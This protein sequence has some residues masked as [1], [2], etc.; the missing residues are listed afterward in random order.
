MKRRLVILM[1]LAA[2]GGPAAAA[3]KKPEPKLSFIFVERFRVEA[4]DNA[5]SLDRAA[6]DSTA[7]TRNR[8]TLGLRWLASPGLE[9]LGK[10]TNEF[11]SYLAPKNRPFTWNEAFVDNLY[12]RGTIPGQVPLTI[13]A[14]RQ[15]I[16]LGEGFVIADSTPLDGSRSYYFNALRV[17]AGLGPKRTL[18]LFVHAQRTTDRYLPVIHSQSQALVEQPEKALA[19]YYSGGFGKATLD[20]YALRR[21]TEATQLW[22]IPGKVNTFGARLQAPLVR[23][24]SLA[25]EGAVQTGSYGSAGRSAYGAIAHLDGAPAWRVPWLKTLTLG[26]ILLSGDD[27]ATARVE[28]WDPVFS[29]WPKWSDGYIYTLI[30]ESRVAYW[31]NLNSLYGALGFDFGDRAN[32]TLTVHRLGA[33][34]SR[35]GAFPGGTG[36]DRGSLVVGHLNFVI[37]RRLTGHFHWEHFRPGSFYAP[38]AAGFHWIRFELLFRS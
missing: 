22:P 13:T 28:G 15:D 29:R 25:A 33:A 11:R 27:P 7:Y 32:A 3:D 35:P 16:F 20:A 26:G 4:W 37:G 14:G 5:V 19:A 21:T 8:T 2:L 9:V 12:V 1:L 23:R 34:H 36:L 6:G 38:G 18:T 31:S 24:L 10:I 30:K 17:D